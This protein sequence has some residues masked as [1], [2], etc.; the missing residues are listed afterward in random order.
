[1]E[2]KNRGTKATV[3]SLR[4]PQFTIASGKP[5]RHD[6]SHQLIRQE[7][8]TDATF[9]P[10]QNYTRQCLFQ[11]V[12]SEFHDDNTND[13]NDANG[14]DVSLNATRSEENRRISLENG[15]VAPTRKELSMEKC[16]RLLEPHLAAFRQ[17]CACTQTGTETGNKVGTSNVEK[18]QQQD[19]DAVPPQVVRLARYFPS[20]WKPIQKALI[21]PL[22]PSEVRQKQDTI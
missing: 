5:S 14:Y 1:M 16:I 19:S 3:C 7:G 10:I 15:T 18:Q 20:K 9:L 21:R 11:I 22:T 2:D 8:S 6:Q 4:Q 13:E 17:R 12:Y